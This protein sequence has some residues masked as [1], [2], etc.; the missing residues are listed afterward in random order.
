MQAWVGPRLFW[1]TEAGRVGI[2]LLEGLF[3][4][5]VIGALTTP[6]LGF[7]YGVLVRRSDAVHVGASPA[8]RLRARPRFRHLGRW[9][10]R[11]VF[12]LLL[13]ALI[14]RDGMP[15]S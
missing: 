7:V 10:A 9:T 15:G 14:V 1:A 13:T 6:V 5:V 4:G 2:P 8:T 3:L 12:V 11:V